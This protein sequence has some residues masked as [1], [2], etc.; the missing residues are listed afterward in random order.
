MLNR[1]SEE[2]QSE[3]IIVILNYA[4]PTSLCNIVH[5]EHTLPQMILQYSHIHES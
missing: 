5:W 3:N 1:V 2:Q 4:K